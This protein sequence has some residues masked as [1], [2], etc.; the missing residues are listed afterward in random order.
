MDTIDS[1][2]WSDNPRLNGWLAE[3]RSAF[4]AWRE[5][6]PGA[7]DFTPAS[8][9]RLEELVRGA[10]SSY[11]E[12]DAASDGPLL[13]VAAW[14]L[15]E[16]QVRGHGAEWR[17]AP[18][19]GPGRFA[20]IRPLVTLSKERLDEDERAGLRELEELYE[21]D[22]PLCNPLDELLALFLRGPDNHLR[23]VLDQYAGGS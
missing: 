14:Y 8:V 6:A 18:A 2:E 15:G 1:P 17:C 19:P 21:S 13:Q 23:D 12:A 10:F 22:W 16:V 11:E 9:D 4:P 3:Q 5:Q 20:K 7:W